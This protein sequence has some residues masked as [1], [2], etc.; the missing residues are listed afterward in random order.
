MRRILILGGTTEARA[1]AVRLANRDDVAVTLSLA[2]RTAEP[3]AHAV[4]TIS[5]G[6]GGVR[7]LSVYL[8][9]QEV[10]LLIDATHPFAARMSENAAAAA[11]RTGVPLIALRR[12]AWR[13]REGDRWILVRDAPE[14]VAALGKGPRRVFLTL[15]R[16]EIAPFAA[17]PQH[18]YL[19]RSV[20]PVDPPLTLPDAQYLLSRGPFAEADE[21]ALL[22]QWRIDILV[23][24]NSGG[25][26]TYGKIAAARSLDLE[27][28]MLERPALPQVPAAA[29]VDRAMAMI[30]QTL[31]LA[32]RGE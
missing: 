4:P 30:H 2:G 27:V 23:S 19:V 7:G 26:A 11:S 8:I 6:F 15:G 29:D 14:A 25:E 28:I 24:K 3:V 22:E 12:Q 10:D 18:F 9:D 32:K 21:R 5:G 16:Q 20:D 13:R 1:L 17:A 31:S